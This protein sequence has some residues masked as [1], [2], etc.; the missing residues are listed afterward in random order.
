MLPKIIVLALRIP[1]LCP[2]PIPL[3]IPGKETRLVLSQY[4]IAW[5]VKNTLSSIF[6]LIANAF[7]CTLPAQGGV[8][9]VA[10]EI[11]TPKNQS[12]EIYGDSQSQE[13]GKDAQFPY[14]I[15]KKIQ[16]IQLQR[17]RNKNGSD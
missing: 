3:L 4:Q 15:V 12:D 7:L 16:L 8:I 11:S 2:K 6:S 1:E 14:L 17:K 13:P 5:Y 10:E 9:T